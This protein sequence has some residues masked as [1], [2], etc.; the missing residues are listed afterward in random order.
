MIDEHPIDC[1]FA[2][3]YVPQ[4][5]EDP[6]IDVV[7]Q[8]LK[9]RP[10]LQFHIEN[11]H[12]ELVYHPNRRKCWQGSAR[13]LAHTIFITRRQ[14]LRASNTGYGPS[15][16][17]E[18]AT[19]RSRRAWY[20]QDGLSYDRPTAGLFIVTSQSHICSS[21]YSRTKQGTKCLGTS[22]VTEK[23]RAQIVV[24]GRSN[25]ADTCRVGLA[26][27]VTAAIV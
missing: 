21:S 12:R 10:A 22:R 25:D 20:S 5:S 13:R 24:D 15:A 2:A 19:R 4:V 16:Q 14:D 6:E 18:C 9:T 26:G 27:L 1:Q 7:E 17:H 23:F 8:Y 3:V 11:C